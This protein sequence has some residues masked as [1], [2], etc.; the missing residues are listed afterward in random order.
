MNRGISESVKGGNLTRFTG[1]SGEMDVDKMAKS[2][3]RSS[4]SDVGT[5]KNIV[6]YL[7]SNSGIDIMKASYEATKQIA[8]IDQESNEK[9]DQ[10]RISF[11]GFKKEMNF[12]EMASHLGGIKSLMDRGSRRTMARNLIRGQ[13]LMERGRTSEA[14]AMGA[15]LYLQSLK[16]QNIPIDLSG[17]SSLSRMT[18]RAWSISKRDLAELQKQMGTQLV[19]STTRTMGGRSLATSAMME[20]AGR[21]G[22]ATAEAAMQQA[23]LP[24]NQSV[25]AGAQ[26]D[27]SR[28]SRS[29]ETCS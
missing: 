12:K 29:F 4:G 17:K 15:N 25:A 11:D 6:R 5:Q 20:L 19:S 23:Y 22:P 27:I 26:T 21:S 3:A 28:I 2:I 16:D 9:L 13:F 10:L 18:Q 7:Q 24:E 8:E 1:S 14:R